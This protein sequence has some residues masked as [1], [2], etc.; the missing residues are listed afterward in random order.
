MT[1]WNDILRKAYTGN[2]PQDTKDAVQAVSDLVLYIGA[3]QHRIPNAQKLITDL[4]EFRKWGEE[5]LSK[6]FIEN[7]EGLL[8]PEPPQEYGEATTLKEP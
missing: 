6:P 3:Q 8:P 2:E 5:M 4:L 7:K 1:N